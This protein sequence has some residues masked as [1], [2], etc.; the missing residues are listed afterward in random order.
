MSST[1][2]DKIYK[3]I[4]KSIVEGEINQATLLTERGLVE[5]YKV[6]KSP[7]REALVKLCNQ[8]ILLSLPRYGYRVYLTDRKY[9][10]SIIHFRLQIE[11]SYLEENFDIFTSQDYKRIRQTIIPLDKT[12]IKTPMEYWQKTSEFHLA[13]AKT[14]QD[15]FMLDS[16]R[17]ILEKQLITFSN[18]Y[19]NNWTEISDRKFVDQ[20]SDILNAIEERNLEKALYYL[21][22]D[23]NSF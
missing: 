16:L 3:D 6:S 7:V 14:Y 21:R 8:Q 5:K 9:L 15:P 4:V 12:A 10:L 2:S 17:S 23:I 19:W 18:L 20:H 13:L 22:L 11:T 1:I